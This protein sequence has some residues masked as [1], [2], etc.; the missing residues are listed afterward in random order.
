MKIYQKLNLKAKILL[1]MVL[2]FLLTISF[3]GGI[4]YYQISQLTQNDKALF[5]N[6]VLEKEKQG[7]KF[8]VETIAQSLS[9]FYNENKN[10]MSEE[11]LLKEMRKISESVQFGEAGYF[12][13]YDYKG[14]V[15]GHGANQSLVGKNLINLTRKRTDGTDQYVIQDLIKT[16][17]QGGGYVVSLWEHPQTKKLEKKFFYVSPIKGTNYW[18]GSGDY[19]SVINKYLEKQNTKIDQFKSN[20]LNILIISLI[21]VIVVSIFISAKFSNYLSKFVKKIL[22]GLN[23]MAKG[24]FNHKLNINSH[25]ELEELSVTFNESNKKIR[26]LI[27]KV[28]ELIEELSAYSEELSSATNEETH[29][30]SQS[31]D[32][33]TDIITKIETISTS[34]QEIASLSEVATSQTE[35]GNENLK[36]AIKQI[37]EINDSI[38]HS[39]ELIHKLDRNSKEIGEII[40]L[41]N[42]IA[43]QTNLLALNAAIEAAQAGEAGQGFSVVAD[44]IRDL[45]ENTSEATEKIAK[46][47]KETQYNSQNS[48]DSIINISQKAELGN[49][50]IEKAGK[51][52]NQIQESINQTSSCIQGASNST[53]ELTDKSTNVSNSIIDIQSM[54]QNINNSSHELADMAQHLTELMEQF[55]I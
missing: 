22:K 5:K 48:L 41:I 26:H 43:E 38:N 49:E 42:N 40:D 17:K 55:K 32:T 33:I 18:I 25:D 23:E 30:T 19:E 37:K 34:S 7:S 9:K 24:N 10:K 31:V 29:I 36:N 1:T 44:E 3:V 11:E 52:F 47:I 15:V 54:S 51:S 21:L 16:A 8:A 27:K 46:L 20:I 50:L 6:V 13:M 12:Y 14:K 2:T 35:T 53:E 28:S 39:V 45:A 4:V